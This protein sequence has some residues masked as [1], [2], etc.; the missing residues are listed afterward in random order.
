MSDLR[1]WAT[2]EHNAWLDA[3]TRRAL[4]ETIDD[5]RLPL[6]LEPC[7]ATPDNS[8]FCARAAGHAGPHAFDENRLAIGPRIEP[9]GRPR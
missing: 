5:L 7:Y 6:V 4:P 1:P 2:S 9:P 8:R 3:A